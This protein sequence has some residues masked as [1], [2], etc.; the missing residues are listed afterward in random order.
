MK[1]KL[2]RL[3]ISPMKYTTGDAQEWTYEYTWEDF[4]EAWKY[5]TVKPESDLHKHI[6]VITEYFIEHPDKL[7]EGGFFKEKGFPPE[8]IKNILLGK[9]TCAYP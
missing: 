7:L 2:P 3:D 5:I 6:N 1:P 8:T 9:V 4:R